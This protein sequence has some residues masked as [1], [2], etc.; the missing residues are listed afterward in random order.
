MTLVDEHQRILMEIIEQGRRRLAGHAAGEVPRIIL[1]AMAVAN[2]FHHLQI[3]KRSL[4]DPLRFK[5]ASLPFEQRLPTGKL[6]LDRF[7]GLLDPRPR[8]D[9]MALGINGEAIEHA[10]FIA[11]QRIKRAELINLISPQLNSE[12]DALVC[13]MHLD[14][15]PAD[16]ERSAPDVDVVAFVDTPNKL[17]KNTPP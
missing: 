17:R 4:V 3:E 1:D 10:Q 12:S 5:Q 8:H 14:R 7:D 6:G 9:E 2:L 15:V 11:G 16:T 13:R